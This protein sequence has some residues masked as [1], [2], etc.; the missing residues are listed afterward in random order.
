MSVMR[1]IVVVRF[2]ELLRNEAAPSASWN[3]H[4][5]APHD[6]HTCPT[7]GLAMDLRSAS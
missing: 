2:C 6:A 1:A 4:N 3:Q 7:V 5:M